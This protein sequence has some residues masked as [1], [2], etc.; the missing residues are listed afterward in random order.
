MSLEVAL[1]TGIASCA[2]AIVHL[3]FRL[4]KK[5]AEKDERLKKCETD[6]ELLWKDR[7]ALWQRIAQMGGG[8]PQI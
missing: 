6:R 4:E 5:D 2:T 8:G 7:E 3:Y 1:F